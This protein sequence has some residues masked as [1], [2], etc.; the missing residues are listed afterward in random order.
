MVQITFEG[1][2]LIEELWHVELT[3]LKYNE[4]ILQYLKQ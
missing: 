3:A 1:W 2:F 4:W